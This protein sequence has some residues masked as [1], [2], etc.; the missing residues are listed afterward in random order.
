MT[1]KKTTKPTTQIEQELYFYHCAGGHMRAAQYEAALIE[2]GFRFEGTGIA[3][4][5]YWPDGVKVSYAGG[6]L[7]YRGWKNAQEDR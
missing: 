7:I 4:S 1:T 3:R 2:A 6:N 5:I